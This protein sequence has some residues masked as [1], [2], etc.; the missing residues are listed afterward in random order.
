MIEGKQ[1]EV[2]KMAVQNFMQRVSVTFETGV[3]IT[4]VIRD[5][6]RGGGD[7]RYGADYPRS[8]LSQM[9]LQRN[10]AEN[11]KPAIWLTYTGTEMGAFHSIGMN[12]D[13]T[14]RHYLTTAPF[15][16]LPDFVQCPLADYGDVFDV[17]CSKVAS[18]GGC[19]V[20]GV[21]PDRL[22]LKSCLPPTAPKLDRWYC[23]GSLKHPRLTSF[24]TNST[25]R[26]I[27]GSYTLVEPPGDHVYEGRMFD[28]RVRPW[29]TRSREVYW[30]EPYM[31]QSGIGVGISVAAA[32]YS[33]DGV[34]LGAV[35]TDFALRTM[36]SLMTSLELDVP[37]LSILVTAELDP[38]LVGSIRYSFGRCHCDE[39]RLCTHHVLLRVPH[40]P[41]T[42]EAGWEH[43]GGVPHAARETFGRHPWK[44]YFGDQRNG[45]ILFTDVAQPL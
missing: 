12:G 7:F 22:C 30:T 8:E 2:I 24:T 41:A 34:F 15:G 17:D 29:Y 38:I 14:N 19:T 16:N 39:H 10:V 5:L 28:P 27:N 43:G 42:E 40:T 11:V 6:E 1:S 36:N 37:F 20:D 33:K 35:A 26:F 13:G 18:S 45:D 4:K 25:E 21:D 44:F 23:W 3:Q 31:F 9:R 32:V